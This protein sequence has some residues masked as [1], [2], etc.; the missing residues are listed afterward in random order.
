M[1]T[2]FLL[3]DLSTASLDAVLAMDLE[4]KTV[5]FSTLAKNFYPD[6]DE[7]SEEF[8]DLLELYISSFYVE[9]LYRSNRF[10]NEKFTPIYTTTGLIR[11][12]V[13]NLFYSDKD[14]IVH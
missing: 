5:Y 14:L 13:A 4:N 9:K 12:I 1:D 2:R 6:I 7:T 8:V 11:D 3:E 10:F